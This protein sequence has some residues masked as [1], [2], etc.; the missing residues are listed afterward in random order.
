MQHDE[1]ATGAHAPTLEARG[2]Q[3]PRGYCLR[4]LGMV[5]RAARTAAGL[6]QEFVADAAGL[7]R[8]AVLRAESGT[9][10][11]L[12]STVAAIVAVTGADPVAVL[13]QGGD[14]GRG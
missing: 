7:S 11:P 9:D 14:R 8:H 4:T 6:S 10:C 2:L 13:R 12:I 5:L 1:D 3:S